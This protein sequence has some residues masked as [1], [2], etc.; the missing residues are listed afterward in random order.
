MKRALIIHGWESNS[1]EHWYQAEKEA[2]EEMGYQVVVPDMP[3]S[4]K[5]VL[6]EWLG[7]V[8]NF[9]PDLESVL[10]GHS[11]GVPTILRYLE[12]SKLSINKAIL[13]AGF[14]KDLGM[15]E[16]KGFVKAPFDWDRIKKN[17]N[18]FIVI[19]QKL[20]P[21][22]PFEVGQELAKNLGVEITVAPGDNHFDTMELDL[23]NLHL[24]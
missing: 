22:V 8:N 2:L 5:P 7:V 3:N 20:D 18:D 24:R 21:W 1:S 15:E 6:S 14:A 13:L 23:I 11:L 19:N 12:I 4:A 10:I 9:N 17:A 16:L